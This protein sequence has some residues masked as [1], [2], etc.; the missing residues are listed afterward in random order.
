ML[1]FSLFFFNTPMLPHCSHRH[2]FDDLVRFVR[3]SYRETDDE[4]IARMNK[5]GYQRATWVFRVFLHTVAMS[6]NH[7]ALAFSNAFN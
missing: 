3:A 1:F 4:R 2:V 6:Q 7:G 5:V